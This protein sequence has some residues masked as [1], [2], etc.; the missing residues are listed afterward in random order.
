MAGLV[1][2]RVQQDPRVTSAISA[3]TACVARSGGG[4]VSALGDLRA[5]AAFDSPGSSFSTHLF[6][7]DL[8]CQR[9]SK[10][11]EVLAEVQR[12]DELVIDREFPGILSNLAA[13]P[14]VDGGKRAS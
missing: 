8:G 9:E 1:M 13:Q 10:V 3:W 14:V 11:A 12:E 2:A 5:H 6:D 4:A 7:V